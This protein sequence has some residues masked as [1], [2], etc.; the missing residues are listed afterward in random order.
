MLGKPTLVDTSAW[1]DYFRRKDVHHSRVLE[2]TLEEGRAFTAGVIVAELFQ[3]A[4]SDEELRAID[5]LVSVVQMVEETPGIWMEAG[6]LSYRL[7]RQGLT[8]HIIDCY[9]AALAA[10][11]R[12]Q[13]LSLD[14]HFR[15]LARFVPI[16]LAG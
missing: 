11:H 13:I 12:L 4:S 2:A 1:I 16:Q 9:L 6:R 14:H 3:G 8:I 7:R 5:H 15:T 10:A